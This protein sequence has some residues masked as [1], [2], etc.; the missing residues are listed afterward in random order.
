MGAVLTGAV[1]DGDTSLYGFTVITT[2]KGAEALGLKVPG[3]DYTDIWLTGDPNPEEEAEIE[4]KISQVAMR[5]WMDVDNQLKLTREYR[6]KK[7]RQILLFSALILLFFA[8]SVFMQVSGASRRIRSE[9]RTIGTLRAVGADL[10]TLVGCYRLPVLVC[11]AAGL[12]PCLLFYAVTEI[13]G[14]R[15]F[16]TNH[17]VIMIPVLALLAGCIALACVADIRRRLAGVCCQS[18]VENIREL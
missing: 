12:I 5:G 15:L 9:T 8:V 1:R 6:T 11:A 7:L 17:P 10:K 14:L 16:S 18:I 3:P 13:P 4:D 2:P